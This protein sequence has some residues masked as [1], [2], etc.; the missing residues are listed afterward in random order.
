MYYT[1]DDH[2]SIVG[3][4]IGYELDDREVGIRVPL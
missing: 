1:E 2:G 4:T 3:I